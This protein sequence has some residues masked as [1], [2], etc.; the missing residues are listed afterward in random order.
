MIVVTGAAGFVGSSMVQHLNESGRSDLV[1][2]EDFPVMS[3]ETHRGTSLQGEG[4]S[5]QTLQFVEKI[6]RDFFFD[7]LA[8][9]Q[10]KVDFIIHLGSGIDALPD[11]TSCFHE[12]ILDFSQRLWSFAAMNR[13]PLLFAA[14]STEAKWIWTGQEWMGQENGKMALCYELIR[15]F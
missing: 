8:L 3:V 13:I 12:Y 1:L 10:Q 15:V 11:D 14:A 5:L 4:A 2:V 6:P 9:N 7:W